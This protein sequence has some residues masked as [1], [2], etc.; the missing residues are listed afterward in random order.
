[1]KVFIEIERYNLEIYYNWYTLLLEVYQY[2][3]IV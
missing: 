1:M 2:L 3:L